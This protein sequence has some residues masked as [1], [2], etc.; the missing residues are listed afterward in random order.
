VNSI[1]QLGG[2][3]RFVTTESAFIEPAAWDR[4][5]DPQIGHAVSSRALSIW[6]GVDASIKHDRTAIVAVTWDRKAQQVR[7]VTHRVFQPS[8]EEPLNFEARIERTLLDLYKRFF[9]RKVLFDPWQMQ[10]VAQ[11]LTR[12]GLQLEEFPQSPANL[13]AIAQNLYDLIRGQNFVAYRD[14]GIRE[15]VI[16]TVANETSRGWRLTKEKQSY[17]IDV[18]LAL[19]MAAY[20]AVQGQSESDFDWTWS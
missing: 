1:D 4:C 16:H 5:V 15:A 7:L 9:L 14:D 6:V 10:S 3:N 12:A 20:A 8:P 11:R 18:V 13:T 17:K 2:P 19:A